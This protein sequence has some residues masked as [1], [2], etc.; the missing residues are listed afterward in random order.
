M[1]NGAQ[2]FSPDVFAPLARRTAGVEMDDAVVGAMLAMADRLAKPVAVVDEILR[3]RRSARVREQL[4]SVH[5]GTT[6]GSAELRAIWF[7]R[8]AREGFRVMLL[9]GFAKAVLRRVHVVGPTRVNG[10][11]VYAIYHTP[12][13]R[14]LA[15]WMARQS[16]S[17]VFSAQRWLDRAGKAHV[18]CTWRGL[19][20]LVRRIKAGSCA[21]ITADHFD[22]RADHSAAAWILGRE[23]QVSTGM[24]RI[25]AAAC[26][27]IVPVMTRYRNGRVELA[28][29][30]EIIVSESCVVDG[31]RRVIAV[32]DAELR[33]DP[34][35]WEQVHR[36]LSAEQS[37]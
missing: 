3:P 34:S 4:C 23:V 36:F 33:R 19:R 17:V 18:P 13:G 28:M 16:D 8:I 29:G 25:A 9:L 24:A 22:S 12:W 20:E 30:P 7:A 26:V 32:F 15:L 21:A 10:S 37:R 5:G 14:V 27:P 31:T 35:S 2:V 11:C 1:R 6:D